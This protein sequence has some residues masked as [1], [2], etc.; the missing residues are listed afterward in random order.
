MKTL[1]KRFFIPGRKCFT[2]K[3]LLQRDEDDPSN[4]SV[5]GVT[6]SDMLRHTER[7][8][9]KS[10]TYKEEKRKEKQN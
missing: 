7:A 8:P 3:T 10:H 4:L 5:A 1:I 9:Y 2:F 6:R